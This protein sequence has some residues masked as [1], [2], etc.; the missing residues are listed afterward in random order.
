MLL[1]ITHCGGTQ[2]VHRIRRLGF[3]PVHARSP[4]SRPDTA[5]LCLPRTR[6][7]QC[8]RAPVGRPTHPETSA[9]NYAWC[10]RRR[11]LGSWV[12]AL[13]IKPGRCE[14]AHRVSCSTA[15]ASRAPADERM[16]PAGC[17]ESRADLPHGRGYRRRVSEGTRPGRERDALAAGVPR[18]LRDRDRSGGREYQRSFGLLKTA[19]H[20]DPAILWID[21]RWTV[22]L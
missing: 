13:P 14:F 9:R 10:S 4:H 19:P 12:D 5:S 17:A 20:D 11:P 7:G 2:R 6:C 8:G 15:T 3:R 18:T 16:V 21:A 1:A 22:R